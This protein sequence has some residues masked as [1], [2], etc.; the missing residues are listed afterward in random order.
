[1]QSQCHT[2]FNTA[3]SLHQPSYQCRYISCQI[4]SKARA[5]RQRINTA[6]SLHQ[7]SYQ[8]R[9][10][11]CQIESKARAK[12]QRRF[13][14]DLVFIWIINSNYTLQSG[15]QALSLWFP[16]TLTSSD[17]KIHTKQS[18]TPIMFGL[19]S[20]SNFNKLYYKSGVL[21]YATSS[22]CQVP[23]WWAVQ[24]NLTFLTTFKWT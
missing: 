21:T 6:Q 15:R 1:M 5:K 9:Y 10:I 16:K 24:T 11:S 22:R 19:H 4:E 17:C 20:S 3:Q 14:S 12:R 2:N 8:C 7:P 23:T 13:P 18:H